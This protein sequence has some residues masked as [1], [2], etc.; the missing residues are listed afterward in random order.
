LKTPPF[1][2]WLA[3]CGAIVWG[4]VLPLS[5]RSQQ[6]DAKNSPSP[7]VMNQE[8]NL[9][10]ALKE[11]LKTGWESYTKHQDE[12]SRE[13][14]QRAV[15]L[16]RE[17]KNAWGEGE[18]HRTLGLIALGAAKYPESQAEFGQALALFESVPS[19]PRIA[20]VHWHLGVVAY[21]MGK[22]TEAAELYR[23]ALS[24]FEAL[25]DLRNQ[26]N[27]LAD[28]HHV[29]RIPHEERKMCAERGLM[30]ARKIG[31][32]TLEGAFLHDIGDDL[33]AAGDFAGAIEKLR[34]AAACFEEAGNRSGLASLWTSMGRLYRMHG[35]YDEAISF[36]QKGLLIQQELGDK[37]GVI[38]SLNAMAISYGLSGHS[39]EA[40]DHYERALALA[41]ET[42]S[43]RV[44][45]FMTGNLGG[46][47]NGKGNYK[48]AIELLGESI[49]LDPSSSYSGNRYL[50]LSTAYRGTGQ[51]QQALESAD[52][53][54]K[55]IR[56]AGYPDFL[57]QALQ[58]RGR[59]YQKLERYPEALADTEDAIRVVEQLRAQLVPSDYLKQGYAGSTQ[60]LFGD[61]IQ[62]QEKLG[63]HK[64]AMVMAEEARARAFLDLLASR[65][66]EQGTSQNTLLTAAESRPSNLPATGTAVRESEQ[67]SKIGLTTRGSSSLILDDP[68][69]A[70]ML[71]SPVSAA[72]PTFDELLST[73][74][75]LHST[76]LS[77][78]V[79]PDATF[80]W[81]LGPDGTVRGQRVTV[82]SEQLAKLIRATS[83]GEEEPRA[84][85]ES[86]ASGSPAKKPTDGPVARTT[87]RGPQTLR[88]R[89]GGELVL[90]RERAKSWGE[91]YKLLI[92]PVQ[93]SLPPQG[94][95]LT[96]VPQGPL[97]Q[98]SFAALQDAQGHYLVENYA[99]NYA[100]SLGVLRLTWARK[101][102]LGQREP[103][104]LV[105]A[106]PQ[107]A[108]DLSKDM[109][110]PPLPG[111]REEARNL[112]RLLPHGETTLL[113]GADASKQAVRQQVEGKTVLHLA[114]HAIVRDDQPMDSF[115]VLSA[116]DQSP[117]ESG[118]LT[119]QEIYGMDLHTDLVV[120]SA[121]R[122]ALG[123]L[124]GDGMVGLTRAFFY[125]GAPSVMAT[126][127]DVA[128]EPTSLLV[129]NFYS[130]LQRNH[131][132]SRALRT[133]QLRLLR[134]LRAGHVHVDTPVGPITLPED[135]VFWAG[136]VLQGEP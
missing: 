119:V 65:S 131:D 61:A 14:L 125:G 110:L 53:A 109:G 8:P 69:G 58:E 9:S 32:K 105:V 55:L 28:L 38:Q 112:V 101:Q 129:S 79:G 66:P 12:A 132:K 62:I 98:L 6:Q 130:A 92:L 16:A 90:G 118:R 10:P 111:A 71:P 133:A 50:E 25:G 59:V 117:P 103:R 57:Y 134:A 34:E 42:G 67:A 51:Y 49:R 100:P 40:M 56:K 23:Q 68:S 64:E 35:A 2:L 135:P 99:L 107:I 15:T 84:R 127:W 114:T 18:A 7:A 95:H 78:W 44:I 29:D 26:A 76:L 122:T 31:D 89:G 123:K 5:L 91:L 60:N 128:D 72:A 22:R 93:E 20:L 70:R 1:R 85:V 52:E 46:A 30:L 80:V 45:A 47:S 37:I 73:A 75:R 21:Y 24:Q 3:L 39:S 120:L 102:R 124:S 121:C 86:T 11:L 115:L 4:L 77:Y 104:Y 43:P 48:R 36:Y 27:V 63:K 94:S 74:K 54:V 106:D 87:A 82:T 17:E 97:F 33:F 81:A 83:Y 41:R 108:P 96:I 88:L 19:L 116:G 13:Q 126:L 113:M 136:L